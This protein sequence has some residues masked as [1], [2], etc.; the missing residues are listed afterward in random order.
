MLKHFSIFRKQNFTKG[1]GYANNVEGPSAHLHKLHFHVL[2]ILV[3]YYILS[4]GYTVSKLFFTE[5]HLENGGTDPIWRLPDNERFELCK[6]LLKAK[7]FLTKDEYDTFS[8]VQF[9]TQNKIKPKVITTYIFMTDVPDLINFLS[10]STQ[11]GVYLS[12]G[13]ADHNYF[14]FIQA[15]DG[16]DL[17]LLGLAEAGPIADTKHLDYLNLIDYFGKTNEVISKFFN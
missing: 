11:V 1:E 12:W 15:K 17:Q 10:C 7:L 13:F 3:T 16:T 5:Q 6:A 9:P 4:R 2:P 14:V 8:Y